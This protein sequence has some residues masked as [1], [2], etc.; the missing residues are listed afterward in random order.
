MISRSKFNKRYNELFDFDVLPNELQNEA[1]KLT[2]LFRIEDIINKSDQIRTVLNSDLG[3]LIQ[4]LPDQQQSQ[5]LRCSKSYFSLIKY[6]RRNSDKKKGRPTKLLTIEENKVREW[7]DTKSSNGIFPTKK[8]FKEVC[9][10]Y[11]EE[12]K[13]DGCWSKNYFNTLLSR[14]APDYETCIAQPLDN[15]R[16]DVQLEDLTQYFNILKS[17]KIEQIHPKLII[18][19]DET[20]FGGS[21]SVRK[22]GRK[23]LVKRS[24]EGKC[25]YQSEK[26]VNL[27]SALVAVSAYGE[28]ISPCC[29][30]QRGTEHPDQSNCPFYDKMKVFSTPNAFITR[31]VFEKYLNEYVFIYIEKVRLEIGDENAPALI[32]YDGHKAHLSEILFAK[33][34][35]KNIQVVII[36]PHSSHILQTL[37]QGIFRSMKNDY[38]SITDW[39][40]VSKISQRLQR[41]FTC[42]ER[43]QNHQLI[44]KS[45]AKVGICPIIENGEVLHIELVE[46]A[47]LQ[48]DS[49]LNSLCNKINEKERGKNNDTAAWGLMNDEERK[50]VDQGCCALCGAK[51]GS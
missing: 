8:E 28:I 36:P 50:R 39:P 25:F 45:W 51:L 24:Y 44:L 15:E 14:I 16:G 4:R 20:G 22:I 38:A 11:L 12:Q 9:I 3:R 6:G 26:Q 2:F 29:I 33:C 19:L 32:I 41:I 23:V 40:N 35:M 18:N 34:A 7:L 31:S 37:D 43:A 42:I 1:K 17:L 47:V 49:V 21:K 30:V 46:N 27:I 5:F 10:S 13:F 48:N